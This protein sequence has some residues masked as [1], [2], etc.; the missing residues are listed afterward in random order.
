[1]TYDDVRMVYKVIIIN[2]D[3]FRILKI[4]TQGVFGM[5]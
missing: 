5:F 1:M 2:Y 4:C 3:E